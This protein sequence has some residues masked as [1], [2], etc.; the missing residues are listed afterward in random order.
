MITLLKLQ[1]RS[2][3]LALKSRYIII[4]FFFLKPFFL[5]LLLFDS[6][7]TNV[8]QYF[9]EVIPPHHHHPDR[10]PRYRKMTR[11]SVR[12]FETHS[13]T[14]VRHCAEFI[15]IFRLLPPVTR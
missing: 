4:H 14:I 9:G 13:K 10:H 5:S 3:E 2:T 12:L 7:K 11:M 6:E 15:I 1:N 8:L